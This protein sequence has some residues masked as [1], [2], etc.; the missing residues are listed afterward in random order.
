MVRVFSIKVVAI[1]VLAVVALLLCREF[2]S[3]EPDLQQ[4]VVK[5]ETPEKPQ[6]Q[7]KEALPQIRWVSD[8]P[9]SSPSDSVKIATDTGPRP[10]LDRFAT[11]PNNRRPMVSAEQA[12]QRFERVQEMMAEG[13]LADKSI[14]K[15]PPWLQKQHRGRRRDRQWRSATP[16]QQ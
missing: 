5:S 1:V 2:L 4:P 13:K 7:S 8:R 12:Q 9:A 14:S 10:I 11:D 16:Q 6:Q 15:S 3:P